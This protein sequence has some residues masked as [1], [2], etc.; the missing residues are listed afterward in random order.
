MA[1]AG[2]DLPRVEVT[3]RAA[4]RRWLEKNHASAGSIWLVIEKKASGGKVSYDDVI[5]E[6]L[7]FGWVD[8]RTRPLD[9]RR[10]M[11][12]FS[13]RKAKSGWSRTNKERV[14]RLVRDGLM[15][16]PGLAKVESAK[17][18]GSWT[19]LDAIENLEVPPDLAAALARNA[20]AGKY[21]KS[22]RRSVQKVILLWIATAKRPETRAKRI[23]E[24]VRLAA[25]GLSAAHPPSVR[26]EALKK[27]GR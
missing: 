15:A 4:W 8:S 5:E 9:E 2:V 7:C 1:T 14:E 10:Y 24:T 16:A 26:G 22:F 17:G 27:S 12:L 19:S 18:D 13:P 25:K 23:D 21:F 3:T 20:A 6:G 11:L